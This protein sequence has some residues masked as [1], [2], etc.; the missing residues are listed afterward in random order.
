[1]STEETNVTETIVDDQ[2]DENYKAPP[3]KTIEELLTMDEEDE[4]LRKYKEALLGSQGESR[5][6]ELAPNMAITHEHFQPTKSSS[7]PTI[8]RTSL[9]SD[10]R[11]SS[12]VVMT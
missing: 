5:S 11:W 9:S 2:H 1:M 7:M 10:S 8:Q 4:S 6:N 12:P 3:Q